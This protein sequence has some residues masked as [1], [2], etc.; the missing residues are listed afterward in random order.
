MV[1]LRYGIHGIRGP[2]IGRGEYG[3]TAF[4]GT[5]SREERHIWDGF[6]FDHAA[7]ILYGAVQLAE[8]AGHNI[9]F[10]NSIERV[11]RGLVMQSFR[12]GRITLG[13]Q[14]SGDRRHRGA[15]IGAE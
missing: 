2:V 13:V 14:Y 5:V 12:S 9:K 11:V 3:V 10:L 1:T 8:L 6:S 7:S 15:P 4:E